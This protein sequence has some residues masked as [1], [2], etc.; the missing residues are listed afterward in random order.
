MNTQEAVER[1]LDEENITKYRMAKDLGIASS[2]SVKGWLRG[3]R[4]STRVAAKFNEVYN[5]KISDAYD[6]GSV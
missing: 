1:I 2:I 5:I 3:T 6:H 4:M